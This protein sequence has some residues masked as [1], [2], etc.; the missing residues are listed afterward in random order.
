M[1]YTPSPQQSA[2]FS[3]DP[4]TLFWEKSPLTLIRSPGTLMVTRL[5]FPSLPNSECLRVFLPGKAHGQRSLAY[6]S[7]CGSKGVRRDLVGTKQHKQ[8]SSDADVAGVGTTLRSDESM[9]SSFLVEI[10]VFLTKLSASNPYSL[11]H[12]LYLTLDLR[13]EKKILSGCGL[14]RG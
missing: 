9:T 14:P 1:P 12:I 6:Y 10:A 2:F 8:A 11:L 5:T 3:Q 7:P 13:E 4:Q